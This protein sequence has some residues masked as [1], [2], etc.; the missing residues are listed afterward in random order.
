LMPVPR[1]IAEVACNR[2]KQTD[3]GREKCFIRHWNLRG[4]CF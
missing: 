2:D 4:K 3:D 1:E